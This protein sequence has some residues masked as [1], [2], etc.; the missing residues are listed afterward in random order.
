[1]RSTAVRLVQR[2]LAYWVPDP[3]F[4][5]FV[6]LVLI[7]DALIGTPSR[8]EFEDR[9][10]FIAA[11]FGRSVLLALINRVSIARSKIEQVVVARREG[12][13]DDPDRGYEKSP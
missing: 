4:A 7:A 10:L 1:M 8:L 5:K 9:F 6:I 13:I 12:T 3:S 2:A 11:S